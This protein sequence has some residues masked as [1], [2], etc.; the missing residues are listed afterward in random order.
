M[1]NYSTS[2][3]PVRMDILGGVNSVKEKTVGKLFGRGIP[4]TKISEKIITPTL[5]IIP[6]QKKH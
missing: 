2:V 6:T 5:V 4:P 3:K 1:L